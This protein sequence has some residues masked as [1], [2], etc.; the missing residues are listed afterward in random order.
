[1]GMHLPGGSGGRTRARSRS[2]LGFERGQNGSVVEDEGDSVEASGG[3]QGA[4]GGSREGGWADVELELITDR[5]GGPVGFETEEAR[6]DVGADV[7]E[8][9][10]VDEAGGIRRRRCHR[11]RLS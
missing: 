9:A 10:E 4:V 7:A 8:V 6:E 3:E 1:M 2:R 5:E 11:D